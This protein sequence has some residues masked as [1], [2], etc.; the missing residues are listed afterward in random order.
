MH[1]ED[2]FDRVAERRLDRHVPIVTTQH[3]ARA[4]AA[5]GFGATYGLR[6]WETIVFRKDGVALRVSSM[7]GKHAPGLMEALIPPA[8]GSMLEF[9]P[10]PTETSLC[11]YISGDTLVCDAL[12]E[13]PRR[14]PDI[15]L[16]LLHLGGTRILGILLTMDGEQGVRALRIVAPRAAIPIHY[17]DYTAFKSPLRDFQRLVR[18]AGLEDRVHYLARGEAYPLEVPVVRTRATG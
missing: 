9:R 11:M 12:R 17:D 4:L 5:K 18:E 16:A 7:P 15:D 13:I 3:A 14:Y 2:Y 1:L 8:M 6:T 10:T